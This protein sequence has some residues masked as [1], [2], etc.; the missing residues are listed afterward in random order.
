MAHLKRELKP[1]PFLLPVEHKDGLKE[2]IKIFCNLTGTTAVKFV[3]EAII[4]E[5]QFRLDGLDPERAQRIIK[6]MQLD[7]STWEKLP[8]A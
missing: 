3:Q 7:P 2:S 5:I 1:R 6:V 8:P 4:N